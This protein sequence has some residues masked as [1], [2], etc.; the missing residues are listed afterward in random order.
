MCSLVGFEILEFTLKSGGAAATEMI[1]LAVLSLLI[2]LALV[3]AYSSR[4]VGGWA[5][6][7]G[8]RVLL[9][10][11][12]GR[13]YIVTGGSRGVGWQVA[14]RLAEAG[15]TVVITSRSPESGEAAA[16]A[17]GS[18]KRHRIVIFPMTLDLE[19]FDSI[20]SF[21]EEC[22]KRFGRLDGLVLNGGIAKSFLDSDSFEVTVD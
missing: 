12:D 4:L 10:P 18:S 15:A 8:K 16:R 5:S 3:V 9:P 21:A 17:I 20:R 22:I 7:L 2:A 14:A 6:V 19:L 11:L 13:I 1:H